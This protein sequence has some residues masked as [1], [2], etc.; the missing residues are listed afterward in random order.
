MGTGRAL[1]MILAEK[2]GDPLTMEREAAVKVWVLWHTVW[3]PLYYSMSCQ[4]NGIECEKYL[5]MSLESN[6]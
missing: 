3:E 6:F 5:Q 1:V 2:Q 4:E